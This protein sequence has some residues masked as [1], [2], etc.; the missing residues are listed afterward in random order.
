MEPANCSILSDK[1]CGGYQR[2]CVPLVPSKQLGP[3]QP[4]VQ[5]QLPSWGWQVPP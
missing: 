2:V 4:G 3:V 5:I 1:G